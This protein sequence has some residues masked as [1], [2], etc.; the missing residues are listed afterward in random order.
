M[1][2][3]LAKAL[4]KNRIGLIFP[5]ADGGLMR[6]DAFNRRWTRYR[7]ACGLGDITPHQF[8]HSYAT[9]MYEAGVDTKA[10]AAFLG[11]T[12]ATLKGVYEELRQDHKQMGTDRLNAYLAQRKAGNG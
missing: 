12:E 3:A 6:K 10:A 4:P 1:L 5:G 9:I 11:D 7:S 8:R 2:D